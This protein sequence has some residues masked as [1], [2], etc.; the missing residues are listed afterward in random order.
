MDKIY[1]IKACGVVKEEFLACGAGERRY[2][3]K[4]NANRAAKFEQKEAPTGGLD[5]LA[6]RRWL[7]LTGGYEP[8]LM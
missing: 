4:Y 5:D 3:P 1:A 2:S 6:Y 8:R 7:H